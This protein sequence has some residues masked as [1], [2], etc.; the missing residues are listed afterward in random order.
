MWYLGDSL[1]K[2]PPMRLLGL[3]HLKGGANKNRLPHKLS[4]MRFLISHFEIQAKARS[5]YQQAD[6]WDI[7]S[8]RQTYEQ[9]KG[10]FFYWPEAKRARNEQYSWETVVR[11]LRDRLQKLNKGSGATL[12]QEE[13]SEHV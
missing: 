3:S 5:M 1:K 2:I 9:T 12:Q 7:N 8:T 10:Y 13:E 4:K 6:Q 11:R